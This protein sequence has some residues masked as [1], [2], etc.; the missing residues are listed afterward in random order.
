MIFDTHTHAYFPEL[1]EKEDEVIAQ[2]ER[3]GVAFAVQVGC[4]FS[5]SKQAL[6]LAERHAEYFSSVGIHPTD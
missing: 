4:D 1:L 3:A 6:E 5:T 2:M